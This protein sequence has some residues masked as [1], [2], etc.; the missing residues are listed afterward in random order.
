MKRNI[1]LLVLALSLMFN[2]FFAVGYLRAREVARTISQSPDTARLAAEELDLDEAQRAVFTE[3]R[4]AMDDER[5]TLREG[6]ALARE[7]LLDELD[8]PSPDLDRVQTLIDREAEYHRQ[9]RMAAA[10]RMRQFVEML[11]PEQRRELFHR[12]DPR[13]V[14]PPHL[15]D[16]LM[17]RFD[18]DGDGTL[19]ESE[20]AEALQHFEQRR[21]HWQRKRRGLIERFDTDGDGQLSE[22][23]RTALREWM[24]HQR[25]TRGNGDAAPPFNDSPG[26]GRDR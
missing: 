14:G 1:L 25:R 20:R 6:I 10:E 17:R 23:E 7:E 11:S 12:I 13:H 3:L 4:S 26:V 22:A 15:R 24:R 16:R 5:E 2:V 19:S 8:R 21:E 18:A 9:L